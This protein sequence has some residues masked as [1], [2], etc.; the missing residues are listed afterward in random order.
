MKLIVNADDFGYS[1]G[2]NLGI[3]EAHRN[4][5]VTSATMMVNM[6]GYEHAVQLAKENPKLGV[7]VHLVLTGGKAVHPQVPSLTDDTGA[8]LR[9]RQRLSDASPE[10]IE[11]EFTAQ[12]ERFLQS[13][14]PLSHLDS[15]H[16]VHAHELVLP[17]VLQL[18]DRYQVPIRNPW[19]LAEGGYKQEIITTEGFSHRFYGDQLSIDLFSEIVEELSGCATAEVMTHPAYLD[20]EVLAGSSYHLPRTKEL[21]IL[22]SSQIREYMVEKGVELVTFHDIR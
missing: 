18:A 13:G 14:L 10:E 15:H 1:K 4:G 19:T 16:H 6:P 22:T 8:F 20:E 5:V 9:G 2:V 21:Q 7:G 17:I 11:R 3:L 12:I